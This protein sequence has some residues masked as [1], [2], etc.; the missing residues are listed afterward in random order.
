MDVTL[1]IPDALAQRLKE[2]GEDLSRRVLEALALDQYKLGHLSATE[3]CDVLGLANAKATEEF[4]KA[5]SA[6]SST[7]PEVEAPERRDLARAAAHGIREMSK[8]VK[9]GGIRIKDLISEG[10]L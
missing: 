5:H 6:T 3:L 9:L 1:H 4:L 2:A 10:R 8:G 7:A